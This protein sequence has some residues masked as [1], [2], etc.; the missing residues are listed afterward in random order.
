M[1]RLPGAGQ[2]RSSLPAQLPKELFNGVAKGVIAQCGSSGCMI[3]TMA[4]PGQESQSLN[5]QFL[6]DSM[7]AMMHT[8]RPDGYLDYFDKRWLEYLDVEVVAA[9]VAEW[10]LAMELPAVFP[11]TPR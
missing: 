3:R 7:P 6:V 10:H 2:S 11:S 5:S 1:F 4:S 9:P 8:A